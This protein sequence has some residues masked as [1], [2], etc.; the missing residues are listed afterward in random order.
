MKLDILDVMN[1][2]LLPFY[3]RDW[4]SESASDNAVFK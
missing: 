1:I 2:I 4:N 3:E